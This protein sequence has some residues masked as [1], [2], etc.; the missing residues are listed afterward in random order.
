MAARKRRSP[1]IGLA[2]SF[3][4]LALLLSQVDLR[5]VLDGLRKID[6]T[7][8]WLPLLLIA[9]G[10][11]I[12]PLR[13]RLIFAPS[14]RPKLMDAFH[15]WSIANMAN[16][17]LP[18]RG[19]DVLRCFLIARGDRLH[20]ASVALA[21]LGLEK[22]LD[23]LALLA[24]I[25]LSFLFL[26]PPTWLTAMV[27]IAS[28]VFGGALVGMIALHHWPEMVERWFRR[29]FTA[30]GRDAL[31]ERVGALL[32]SFAS[33]LAAVRSL[34][35]IMVLVLLTALTWAID[36]ALVWAIANALGASLTPWVGAVVAAILG[37]GLMIPAA[38]GYVGSYEFFSVGTLKMFGVGAEIATA[39]TLAMHAGVLLMT[40]L[41]GV[42]SLAASGIRWSR[43]VLGAESTAVEAT[44]LTAEQPT[45]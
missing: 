22:V 28:A 12:R 33:G 11:S 38:P 7:R 34:S 39:L 30:I 27:I 21:T 10:L 15:V 16:N 6:P 5:G 19:G 32:H 44:A 4:L 23:G 36:A 26:T 8:L 2:I 9:L 1:W 14:Q 42:T 18:A 37:L 35:Q 3:A 40:T 25:L 43:D 24:V 20:G 13:W 17:F 41:F 45:T 31:G 29:F